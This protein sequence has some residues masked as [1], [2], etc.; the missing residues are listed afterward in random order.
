M[1][2]FLKNVVQQKCPKCQNGDVFQSNGN[3]FEL[4]GPKMNEQ[5][6][7]CHHKFEK[8]PGYFIGAMYMSYGLSIAEVVIAFIIWKLIGLPLENFIYAAVVV[9]AALI[10][11]N[12]RMARMIWMYLL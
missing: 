12:F 1:G 10:F 4:K 7:N 3:I 8:E 5:C 11:F 2:Q 9:L 6:A